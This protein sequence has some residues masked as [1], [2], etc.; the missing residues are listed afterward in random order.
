MSC[1]EFNREKSVSRLSWGQK[2]R[3]ILQLDLQALRR[4][5]CLSSQVNSKARK[6]EGSPNPQKIGE[7][8]NFFDTPPRRP[9]YLL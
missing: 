2:G 3:E 8:R 5:L 7:Q 6:R 9:S 4:I 1:R